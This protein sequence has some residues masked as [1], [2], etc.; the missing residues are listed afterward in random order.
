MGCTSRVD[1]TCRLVSGG[2]VVGGSRDATEARIGSPLS[3]L[4]AGLWAS[5]MVR[6]LRREYGELQRLY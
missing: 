3:R 5:V 2:E 6:V 4:V 1:H